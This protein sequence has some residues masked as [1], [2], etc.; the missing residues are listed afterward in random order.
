MVILRNLKCPDRTRSSKKVVGA[1]NDNQGRPKH[2]HNH[3]FFAQDMQPPLTPR[4][5]SGLQRSSARR[6]PVVQTQIFVVQGLL[7]GNS[8]EK[9]PHYREKAPGIHGEKVAKIQI[10]LFLP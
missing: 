9:A 8:S 6:Q 2:N 3:S 4:Q 10:L 1:A 7:C 5:V